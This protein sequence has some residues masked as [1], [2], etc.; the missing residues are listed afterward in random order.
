MS[1]TTLS[2]YQ[3]IDLASWPRAQH[4]QFFQGMNSPYF[5]ICCELDATRLRAYCRAEG[6][7]LFRAYLFLA[8]KTIN[9]QQPFRLRLVDGEIRDYQQISVS[10]VE[11][12]DDETFRFNNVDYD[13]VFESFQANARASAE[14]IK[15]GPFMPTDFQGMEAAL[16]TIH[17]SV[18]PWLSFTSFSHARNL[19]EIDSVPKVVFGKVREQHGRQLM[20]ISVE[21]HHGLMDGLHV[22]RFVERLQAL[23]DAPEGVA[24]VIALFVAGQQKSRPRATFFVWWLWEVTPPGKRFPE[25]RQ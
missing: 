16:D 11:L 15:Q 22:G 10:V 24:G 8:L 25:A 23:F 3:L 12:C 2:S 17:C 7:S 9:E 19:A 5:N 21:V 14:K 20:P 4:F 6:D 18:I 1:E 13:P